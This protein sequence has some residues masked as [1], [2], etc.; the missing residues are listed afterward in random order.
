MTVSAKKTGRYGPYLQLGP[1]EGSKDKPKFSSIPKGM[2]PDSISLETAL[3]L[4]SLPREIGFHP[5]DGK[6]VH[7]GIGRYG[8]Y[9]R[10]NSS[11]ASLTPSDDVLTVGMNRAVELLARKSQGRGGTTSNTLAEL[12]EHPK[13]GPVRILNGRYGPYVKWKRTNVSLP[14]GS[15]VED[16]NL[17][18]A[19]DMLERK[20]AR[21]RVT[22]RKGKASR[23]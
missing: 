23:K 21:K 9:V 10:H 17:A 6:P 20:K 19:V 15:Q 11:F 18:K 1:A 8:P 14:K 4:L 13:G 16:I 12:G 7:S 2:D 3:G 22:R 5:E